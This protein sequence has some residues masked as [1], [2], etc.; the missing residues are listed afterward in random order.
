[1]LLCAGLA[2]ADD[3]V[4]KTRI[5]V[6]LFASPAFVS[7]VSVDAYNN[8]CLSLDNNL[9]DGRVQS[10]LV[11]GH[12]VAGVLNRDDYWNCRFFDNYGCNENS[13]DYLTIPDGVNNLSS[14][15]WGT[16]IRSLRCR[17]FDPSVTSS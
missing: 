14:I 12:D 8:Q 3:I 9:I 15:G 1:M 6:Q 7:E 4:M 16:R 11:G 13:D 10:L 2:V 17:N 5:K